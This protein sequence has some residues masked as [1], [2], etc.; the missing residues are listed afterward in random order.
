MEGA[1]HQYQI[2]M[3]KWLNDL[4]LDKIESKKRTKKNT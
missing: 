3:Y 2:F 1:S 4:L